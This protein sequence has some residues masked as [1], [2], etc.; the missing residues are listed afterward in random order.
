[1]AYMLY[2]GDLSIIQTEEKSWFRNLRLESFRFPEKFQHLPERILQNWT[3][4]E[5]LI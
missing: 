5:F 3:F 4:R 2:V 1:M